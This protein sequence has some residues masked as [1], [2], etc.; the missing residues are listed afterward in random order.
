MILQAFFI[1][2]SYHIHFLYSTP[3]RSDYITVPEEQNNFIQTKL[4]EVKLW[5]NST[6]SDTPMQ[7]ENCNPFQRRLL[8]QE[9]KKQFAD[10]DLFMEP[11]N[12]MAEPNKR[13]ERVIQISKINK[14][15][16]KKKVS[17]RISSSIC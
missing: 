16:Q 7:L 2:I 4:E 8:Y 12:K 6:R 14:D 5:L 10:E 9:V 11:V 3:G 1:V 13:P 15:E 17:I